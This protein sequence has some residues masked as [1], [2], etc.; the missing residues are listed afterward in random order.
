MAK[1]K[2]VPVRLDKKLLDDLD[3][4][5]RRDPESDRSKEVRRALRKVL[6]G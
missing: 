3:A 4:K 5:V 1:S 2:I 6:Y